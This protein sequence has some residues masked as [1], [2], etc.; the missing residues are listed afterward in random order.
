M[1]VAGKGQ[2]WGG[3]STRLR[4]NNIIVFVGSR[5][6]LYT[7]NTIHPDIT[8]S[9]RFANIKDEEHSAD[10]Q[11]MPKLLASHESAGSIQESFAQAVPVRTYRCSIQRG[12]SIVQPLEQSGPQ[13]QH[14]SRANRLVAH[15]LNDIL[16]RDC[17]QSKLC[18]FFL[19]IDPCFDTRA[20]LYSTKYFTSHSH[21]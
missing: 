1:G 17:V 10:H 18:C 7:R 20:R 12:G 9:R 11:S 6:P 21:V 15:E 16:L 19:R 3:C 4:W 8:Y 2:T 14:P 5:Y 13:F